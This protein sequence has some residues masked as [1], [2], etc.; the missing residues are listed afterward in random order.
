VI[1][2]GTIGPATIVIS[3]VVANDLVFVAIGISG[4]ADL[5]RPA[6]TATTMIACVQ[7]MGD[8]TAQH[9]A[10]D[11]CGSITIATSYLVAQ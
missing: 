11:G 10:G 9:Y 6:V 1:G 8:G 4:F 3:Y 5:D 2:P 7:I